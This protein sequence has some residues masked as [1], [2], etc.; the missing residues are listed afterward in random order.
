MGANRLKLTK[1]LLDR[2]A[3]CKALTHTGSNILMSVCGNEDADHEVLRLI[4]QHDTD[5]NY[6]RRSRTA[7]WFAIRFVAKTLVRTR[8]SS[9]LLI[10]RLAADIGDTA[11]HQAARR[12]DLQIV[13]LLLS[14]G[15][16]PSLKNDLGQDAAAMCTS[17]PELQGVLE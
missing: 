9:S 5:V 12:G 16:D 3:S 13:E 15:A 6:Q 11:L 7:K 4:L 1:L 2:G 10:Q 8:M 14:E 17:F